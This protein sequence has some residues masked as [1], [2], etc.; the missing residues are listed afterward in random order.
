MDN[1]T[2]LLLTSQWSGL[3]I[4]QNQLQGY[5]GNVVLLCAQEEKNE[6]GLGEHCIVSASPT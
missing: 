6:A 3:P 5:L 4:T 2:S 1:T